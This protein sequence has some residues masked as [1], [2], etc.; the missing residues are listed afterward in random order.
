MLQFFLLVCYILNVNIRQLLDQSVS[1]FRNYFINNMKKAKT[2][3][4]AEYLIKRVTI[5]NTQILH[6]YNNDKLQTLG[7]HMLNFDFHNTF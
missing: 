7:L 1:R 4:L 6:M 5:Q 3:S 2:F